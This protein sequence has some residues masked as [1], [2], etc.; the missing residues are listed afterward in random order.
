M[1]IEGPLLP[2][3]LW[4]SSPPPP[5]FSLSSSLLTLVHSK[6]LLFQLVFPEI[7]MLL[8][9]PAVSTGRSVQSWAADFL[10][11]N[12]YYAQSLTCPQP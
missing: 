8:E 10:I 6:M 5:P 4:S 12:L 3:H 11:Q 7:F 2:S 9:S 1:Y